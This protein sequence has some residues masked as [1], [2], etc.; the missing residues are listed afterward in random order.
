VFA[1]TE[2]PRFK[3]EINYSSV[4]LHCSCGATF[5]VPRFSIVRGSG[6]S[7]EA[8]CPKCRSSCLYEASGYPIEF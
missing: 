6:E 5:P 4:H 2:S 1:V 8:V 7:V 3:S